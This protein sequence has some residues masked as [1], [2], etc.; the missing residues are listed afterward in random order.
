MHDPN[1]T[2]SR[3]HPLSQEV[4]RTQSPNPYGSGRASHS[5]YQARS[6]P[7]DTALS[8]KPRAASHQPEVLPPTQSAARPKSSYNIQHP[9]R[10]F[11]SSDHSPLSTSQRGDAVAQRSV[12]P[13]KSISSHVSIGEGA[14]SIIPYS[15]D[16]FGVHNPNAPP[17]SSSPSRNGPIVNWHGQEVDPSDHLPVNS[18]AP[19]PEKK[20]A[21]KTYGLGRDREFGPRTPQSITN[22]A[23]RISKDTVIHV[24]RKQDEAPPPLQS[25]VQPSKIRARLVQKPAGGAAGEPLHDPVNYNSVAC[26]PYDD[27]HLQQ[28]QQHGH[29]RAYQDSSCAGF[30]SRYQSGSEAPSIP[31]KV[32]LGEADY[33]D[34]ESLSREISTIDIGSSRRRPANAFVPARGHGDRNIYY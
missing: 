29:G 9:V 18:W 3:P 10:A 19:E 20:V 2:P 22:T 14:R 5:S 7:Y 33:D 6:R 34:H 17:G 21:K 12:V 24:R 13:R 30:I 31:P 23:G 4:P 26:P 16:G 27:H 28:Q 15:P 8:V 11:E 25:E 1:I 32:P